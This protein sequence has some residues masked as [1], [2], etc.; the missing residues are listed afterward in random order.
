M[1]MPFPVSAL[2]F[3]LPSYMTYT[4]RLSSCLFYVLKTKVR[5][6]YKERLP[7]RQHPPTS[8]AVW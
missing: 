3:Q 5:V 1:L 7:R 4:V 8:L 2:R 6:F